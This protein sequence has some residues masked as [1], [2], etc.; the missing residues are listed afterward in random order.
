MKMGLTEKRKIPG[1]SYA[2]TIDG[3]ELPVLDIVVH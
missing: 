1:V 2:I 3:I